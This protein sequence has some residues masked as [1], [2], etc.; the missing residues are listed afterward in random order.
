MRRLETVS[1][2]ESGV[3]GLSMSPELLQVG[4]TLGRGTWQLDIDDR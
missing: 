1:C 2:P 4:T 3:F